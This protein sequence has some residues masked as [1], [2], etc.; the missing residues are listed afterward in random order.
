MGG[1]DPHPAHSI[2]ITYWW[3]IEALLK[4][5]LELRRDQALLAWANVELRND[6]D[7]I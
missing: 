4:Y 5:K 3:Q 6:E 1:Q 7:A 2:H